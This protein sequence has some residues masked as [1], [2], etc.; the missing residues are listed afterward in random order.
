MITK[1]LDKIDMVERILDKLHFTNAIERAS[2]RVGLMKLSKNE[3][4][5]LDK[6]LGLGVFKGGGE[7]CGT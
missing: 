4:I 2:M 1:T 3:L 5:L 7:Q 6:V